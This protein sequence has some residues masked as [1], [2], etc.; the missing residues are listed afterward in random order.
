MMLRKHGLR[1]IV[2]LPHYTKAWFIDTWVFT[3][4]ACCLSS[5]FQW[6]IN[7]INIQSSLSPP[8][9]YRKNN[10][11]QRNLEP[12]LNRWFCKQ[13]FRLII[14][15]CDWHIINIWWRHHVGTVEIIKCHLINEHFHKHTEQRTSFCMNHFLN[16]VFFQIKWLILI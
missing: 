14:H 7:K 4:V 3:I 9:I 11:E 15:V 12:F 2:F 10:T 13:Y 16:Q 1:Y 5:E 8:G 6:T